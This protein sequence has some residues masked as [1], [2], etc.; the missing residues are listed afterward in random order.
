MNMMGGAAAVAGRNTLMPIYPL[1]QYHHHHQSQVAAAMGLPVAM[2]AVFFPQT[3][4]TS[5]NL[6]I[7]SKPIS[8]AVLPPPTGLQIL[9]QRLSKLVAQILQ[10]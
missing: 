9:N 3:I 8:V 7:I 10:A 6:P 4:T 5:P 1:Y 2:A